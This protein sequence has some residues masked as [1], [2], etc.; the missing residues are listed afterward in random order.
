MTVSA[1]ASASSHQIE[2]WSSFRAGSRRRRARRIVD[3][4][5]TTMNGTITIGC[6][7]SVH[8]F[9]RAAKNDAVYG[10]GRAASAKL[11]LE[12][13]IPIIQADSPRIIPK[14][15]DISIGPSDVSAAPSEKR[16]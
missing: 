7:D 2:T 15:T 11:A 13:Q 12:P 4:I 3:A 6:S 16:L 14:P 10:G 9:S 1:P 5:A 8:S